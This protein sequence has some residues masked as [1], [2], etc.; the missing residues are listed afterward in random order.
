[1]ANRKLRLFVEDVGFL[2]TLTL[3]QVAPSQQFV[4]DSPDR[5]NVSFLVI[6]VFRFSRIE[7]FRSYVACSPAHLGTVRLFINSDG[8]SKG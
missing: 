7:N 8:V 3:K 4:E 5:K 6:K 1:M 2:R